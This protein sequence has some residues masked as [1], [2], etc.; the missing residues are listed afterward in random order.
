MNF[1]LKIC[2]FAIFFVPLSPKGDV[3][4]FGRQLML[5]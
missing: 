3:L 1:L 2:V 5:I 4:M